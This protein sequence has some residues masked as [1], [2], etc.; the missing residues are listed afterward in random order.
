MTS[1]LAGKRHGVFPTV[2]RRSG[3]RNS[4]GACP[5]PQNSTAVQATLVL[6][7]FGSKVPLVV[8]SP[9]NPYGF[10]LPS[11]DSNSGSPLS[12][13]HKITMHGSRADSKVWLDQEVL[14]DK[15]PRL[16]AIETD[17]QAWISKRSTREK[18]VQ[19]VFEQLWELGDKLLECS[20]R[21]V[22]DKWVWDLEDDGRFSLASIR[23]MLDSF[24]LGGPSLAT[25]LWNTLL[26]RK[27][28]I[29]LWRVQRD[30]LPTRLKLREKGVELES[31]MRHSIPY[32]NILQT[33]RDLICSVCS[34][35]GESSFH[36]FSLCYELAPIW[37]K[38]LM[39]WEV[40]LP[41]TM[42]VMALAN[43]ADSVVKR[44]FDVV[45]GVTFWILWRYRNALL[46]SSSKPRKDNIFYDIRSY[47]FF[48][49]N[50]RRRK[51]RAVW[52]R[53]L[54]S[55]K[56]SLMSFIIDIVEQRKNKSSPIGAETM[57]YVDDSMA[58]IW[59]LSSTEEYF[60]KGESRFQFD[61]LPIYVI[62]RSMEL[63]KWKMCSL[64]PT[65][66]SS[67]STLDWKRS[68]HQIFLIDTHLNFAMKIYVLPLFTYD[69]DS[70]AGMSK[71][72]GPPELSLKPEPKNVKR[73]NRNQTAALTNGTG[74]GVAY[75]KT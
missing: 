10:D 24:P 51:Y 7:S 16:Y 13:N 36:V 27:V 31:L 26:P 5:K 35:S 42:T 21:D 22:P 17:Q 34:Q 45:I 3:V 72:T 75:I 30:R 28:T 37:T 74:T 53:W 14:K 39:W 56:L 57:T 58:M 70:V 59:Y 4:R 65:F 15:Y 47:S 46:F 33:K 2:G 49:I 64:P 19:G 62:G 60:Q 66:F 48:W 1:S 71:G 40:P 68:E 23:R 41:T 54:Y 6:L 55:P 38:I 12:R 32:K 11:D 52:D 67:A 20:F 8:F 50:N 61:T 18:L 43:W 29:M 73:W 63:A 44:N 9:W 69:M 25:T